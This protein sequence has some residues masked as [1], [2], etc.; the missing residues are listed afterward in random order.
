MI[1]IIAYTLYYMKLPRMYH[2][3]NVLL[4][5]HAREAHTKQTKKEG[6]GD[7]ERASGRLRVR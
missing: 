6:E 2:S 4:A 7:R 3:F 5:S 1:L